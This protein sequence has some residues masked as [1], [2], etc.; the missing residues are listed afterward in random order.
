MQKSA[1]ASHELT[2]THQSI[3][4]LSVI[5]LSGWMS[6]PI[7]A[8]SVLILQVNTFYGA[9]MTIIVG[10]AVLWFIRLGIIMMSHRGRQSTLDISRAYLGDRGAYIIG[11]LLLVST[12][13]WFIAQTTG[14]SK[15]LVHLIDI[16]EAPGINQ[17]IQ[18]SVLLGI[19]ST[20]LCMEGITA[21]RKLTML[22]FPFIVVAFI[23]ALF[24]VPFEI[25][26]DGTQE[27]SLAGI[28]LVLGAHLGITSDLP[29]FFRHSRSLRTSV[30]ALTIIQLV[31][32]ALAICGLYFG[33]IMQEGF[34][35]N[36]AVVLGTGNESLRFSLII[37]VFLSVICA[38]VANVYSASVGW[39]VIAPSAL[40]GRKE[41]LILG[42]GLTTV[43]I[44][45]S[46][47]LSV[48]LLLEASDSALV[49][50][51]MILVLGYVLGRI[52]KRAPS[53][54]DKHTY[55]AAWFLSTVVNTLE[56]AGIAKLE[57][58]PLIVSLAIIVCT[59]GVAQFG[60]MVINI[61]TTKLK[62]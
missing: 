17:F 53:S 46:D 41:Y 6:L 45:V 9:I 15:T 24:V 18:M 62:L 27:L 31:S 60:K 39:E 4:Q 47:L 61:V 44:M 50:L 35:I 5:Q 32:L 25:P 52:L 58:S 33:A 40:V 49:N 38:N 26:K 51:C 16:R 2:D 20:F 22:A 36:S 7:L 28:G 37:L 3:W 19:A 1:A 29:T 48:E 59:I 23:V 57:N 13:A 8:T 21:L 14:A 56:Y 11:A 54:F 30:A 10:N 55:L 42:L 43:F 12:L 34:A